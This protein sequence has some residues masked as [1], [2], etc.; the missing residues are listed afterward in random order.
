MCNG[1]RV[2]FEIQ[3]FNVRIKIRVPIFDTN[4]SVTRDSRTR[5]LL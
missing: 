2:L 4:H 5:N 1:E 3:N